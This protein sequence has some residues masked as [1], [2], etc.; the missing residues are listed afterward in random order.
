MEL[1]FDWVA[2][3]EMFH[4]H[5]RA[6][7]PKGAMP[8]GPVHVVVEGESI[9]E[10]YAENEDLTDW[11]GG[12][13]R[14][15]RAGSAN[16][17]VIAYDRLTLQNAI[18]RSMDLPHFHG[19]LGMLKRDLKSL[20]KEKEKPSDSASRLQTHFLVEGVQ[21]GWNK[22]LPSSYGLFIR[23][24]GAAPG[25]E[26]DFI[27]L[28]RRGELAGFHRPDLSFLSGDRRRQHGDIV[29]YLSEK[30][31]LPVQGLFVP[32]QDWNAWM[33]SESPWKQMAVAVRAHRAK[34]VPF[35]WGTAFI[36]ATRAFVNF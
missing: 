22:I 19:Q 27:L 12:D 1:T 15:L 29:K 6:H 10:A 11:L 5:A 14:E 4:R 21:S 8:S 13:V 34:L 32:A 3:Q 31:L 20:G 7:S 36:M 23:I 18:E 30:Y 28:I 26:Q 25:Q 17:E 9:V 33:E 16:R 35:R 2:Y 24:E